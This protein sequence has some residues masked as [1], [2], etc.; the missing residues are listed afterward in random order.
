VALGGGGFFLDL[1]IK[2]YYIKIYYFTKIIQRHHN[3][4]RQNPK[5]K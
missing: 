1:G 3:D 4:K 2:V 5:I